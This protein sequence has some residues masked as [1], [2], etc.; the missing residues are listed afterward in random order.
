[1][2]CGRA[3]R[4]VR[5]A[6]PAAGILPLVLSLL[7]IS[8]IR[9]ADPILLKGHQEVVY[10]SV[11]LPDGKSVVTASFDRTLKLWDLATKQAVRTM[12]GHPGIILSVDV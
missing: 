6:I 12:E 2:K 7:A 5:A 11:F 10:D 3:K 9:A 1:M 4:I 8:P